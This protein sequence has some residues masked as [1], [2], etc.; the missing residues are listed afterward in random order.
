MIEGQ[1]WPDERKFL[2]DAVLK[3][4]PSISLEVGTWKGGGSTLQI[5]SALRSI[6]HGILHT[7]EVDYDLYQEAI[8]GFNTLPE[9]DFVRFYNQPSTT[10]IKSLIKTN[11][12]PDFVFF[13][14]PE[15]Q[16]LNLND[17]MLLDEYLKIGT[18][19]CMHD[20]DIGVRADGLSSTKAVLIRPYLESLSNWHIIG[21]LTTPV[22]VGIV[23]A[24]K[25]A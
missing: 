24:E 10:L 23:L 11:Q 6:N 22:S 18:Y 13:D 20:W 8:N 19:F 3:R 7:C 15:D 4:K 5:A 25:T 17:F 2:Y 9:N 1:M 16:H 14:G 12:I 21:K